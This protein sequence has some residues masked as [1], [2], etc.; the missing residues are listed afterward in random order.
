VLYKYFVQSEL[1]YLIKKVELLKENDFDGEILVHIISRHIFWYR[2]HAEIN[3]TLFRAGSVSIILINAAIAILSYLAGNFL[4]TTLSVSVLT[5]R[6]LMDLYC[7]H[8]NWKR[9]RS[10][11]EKIIHQIDLYLTNVKTYDNKMKQSTEKYK[12][13][14]YLIG[15]IAEITG[16]E[17][18]EWEK[19]RDNEKSKGKPET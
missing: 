5:I 15:Q 18:N 19:L 7:V 8:S 12:A 10:T 3:K 9:Y 2:R 16:S 4:L 11:L 14:T 13:K 17:M 1:E 6:A